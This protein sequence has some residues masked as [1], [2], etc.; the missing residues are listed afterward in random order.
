MW[1]G[2]AEFV[3]CLT[4]AAIPMMCFDP[5]HDVPSVESSAE[6]EEEEEE[7]AAEGVGGWGPVSR[8]AWQCTEEHV[9]WIGLGLLLAY[10]QAGG[11]F[12]HSFLCW[13]FLLLFFALLHARPVDLTSC[14]HDLL[15]YSHWWTGTSVYCAVVVLVQYVGQVGGANVDNRSLMWAIGVLQYGEGEATTGDYT[16]DYFYSVLGSTVLFFIA[17]FIS[18]ILLRMHA[19][20]QEDQTRSGLEG[21][22]SMEGG[23]S[24]GGREEGRLA[25]LQPWLRTL[26]VLVG[27]GYRFVGRWCRVHIRKLLLLVVFWVCLYPRSGVSALDGVVLLYG[28]V[29]LC[30][31]SIS[32]P[33]LPARG[34]QVL[35]EG[36]L[37]TSYVA[38]ILYTY[39]NGQD[40][41]PT[42][43]PDTEAWLGLLQLGDPITVNGHPRRFLVL[44]IACVAYHIEEHHSQGTARGQGA[45]R[46]HKGEHALFLAAADDPA[47]KRDTAFL[48]NNF[49]T[50][51]GLPFSGLLLLIAGIE[52]ESVFALITWGVVSISA[53][54]EHTATPLTRLEKLAGVWRCGVYA[55]S[56]W[57]LMQ[58]GV[59]LDF[60]PGHERAHLAGNLTPDQRQWWGL[61]QARGSGGLLWAGVAALVAAAQLKAS[62]WGRVLIRG[63]GRAGSEL[64]A[65]VAAGSEA[66]GYEPIEETRESHASEP[67]HRPRHREGHREG[68]GMELLNSEPSGDADVS[69][70]GDD[71]GWGRGSLEED[72]AGDGGLVEG[73]GVGYQS[74]GP[75]LVSPPESPCYMAA[76]PGGGSVDEWAAGALSSFSGLHRWAS[77]E[78]WKVREEIV[79]VCWLSRPAW[80]APCAMLPV[81]V[82]CS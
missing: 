67:R 43:T 11:Y 22:D 39:N 73:L 4:L 15:R 5:S 56:A 80:C 70:G 6:E 26:V 38:S 12:D 19:R 77:L 58:Y 64:P 14:P 61:S 74:M 32:G 25:T 42:A 10:S 41:T 28:L 9:D 30:L 69:G 8:Y 71:E 37:A 40:P 52:S 46:G 13:G 68:V 81:W 34:Y 49:F 60:P 65:P 3:V 23:T 53:Y 72:A 45:P 7:E 55:I 17:R 44:I 59:L 79:F 24:G 82:D 2:L 36:I 47:W 76:G 16:G 35:E 33:G 62:T 27:T 20:H 50:Y 54:V 57:I 78:A 18:S 31:S 75:C 51:L 21:G 29:D 1:S 63:S 66:M 48:L